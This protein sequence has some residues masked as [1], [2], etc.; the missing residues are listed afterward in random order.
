[1]EF[2]LNFGDVCALLCRVPLDD[3]PG[4]LLLGLNLNRDGLD[5]HVR[6]VCEELV[7]FN[8]VP[9][10]PSYI[11]FLKHTVDESSQV[12]AHGAGVFNGLV[13]DFGLKLLDSGCVEGRPASGQFVE[14]DAEGPDVDLGGVLPL[15]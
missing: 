3:L 1:L 4:C 6:V 2:R 15:Q 12:G 5:R 7:V 9:V 13:K 11:A 10:E 8:L 14:N